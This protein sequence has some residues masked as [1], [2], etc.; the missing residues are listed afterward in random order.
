MRLLRLSFIILPVLAF[1]MPAEFA[2][3][4][5]IVS[6]ENQAPTGVV[7]RTGE[8]LP[9]DAKFVNEKAEEVFLSDLLTK[10][11]LLLPVYFTCPQICSFD[12]ANLAL[13]LQLTSHPHDSFNVI[14]LSF[15]HEEDHKDAARS[16]KNYRAM[17]KDEY[18]T[19]NWHFL[20]GTEAEILSVTDAIGY[21]FRATGDGLFLHPSA[22]VAVGTDGK[23]IKY[24]YGTFLAGDVD[25]A[26]AEAEA[27]T[28]ATSIKRF[29]AYCLSGE[30]KQN[31]TVFLALKTGV[32]LV[33]GTGGYFLIRLLRKER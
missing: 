33:L 17:L 14:T 12:M 11:T 30:I 22:L 1:I 19:R 5:N 2:P 28:P 4:E 6:P 15:N 27:G 9:G 7:E 25:L 23:I 26:I 8:F 29:L 10:P 16:A 20:T 13:A 21:T 3:A 31:R 32:L 18:T 24:V